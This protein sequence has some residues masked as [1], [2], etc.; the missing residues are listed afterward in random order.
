MSSG[1]E[2]TDVSNLPRISET[3]EPSPF[4]GGRDGDRSPDDGQT[5]IRRGPSRVGIVAVLIVSI[6]LA[7]LTSSWARRLRA[8][9]NDTATGTGGASSLANMNSFA[10]ALLLGG[11][12]GPLVMFLWTNSE[13]LKNEKNLEDFDTYVEWIR[14]LQPEFDTVHIFQVWNKAYNISVQMA[15]VG[16]KYIT[17]LDALDYAERVEASRPNNVSMIYQMGSIYYDKLGNSQ[18]KEYYKER[19]RTESKPHA[20]R[21]KLAK[22][23]PGWR[24]LELDPVL[25]DKGMILPELLKPKYPRPATIPASANGLWVNGAKLQFLEPYQ[26]FPYG[27]SAMAFGYNYH[28]QAQ[29]LQ[30][31]GGQLHANLSEPV[32]DSRPGLALKGWSEDEWERGRRVELKALGVAIPVERKDLETPTASLAVDVPISAENKVLLPEA[33]YD[34]DLA[35]RLSRDALADYKRH[36][37]EYVQNLQTY[38]SHIDSMEAQAPLLEADRDYLKAMLAPAGEERKKL[39][40]SAA[41]G[42]HDAVKHNIGIIFRYYI[43]EPVAQQVLP[44]GLTRA[45]VDK[46]DLTEDQML[47][48]YI[49]AMRMIGQAQFDPDAEDRGEYQ[50]YVDRA[51]LRLKAIGK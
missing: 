51:M 1:A 13:N 17:I 5:R 40:A 30:A 36:I 20:T 28:R 8:G 23:D 19:V 3:R 41:A 6:L 33:I 37:R 43:P 29:L 26:P 39:L 22:N 32:V 18:E 7:G 31:L 25:D 9:P 16:N 14:L 24:R 46:K 49:N 21:Q 27:V 10:L 34:Y 50:H 4:R 35:A 44:P 15:A 38:Q 45:D 48:A 42:Y 11:L 47:V 2:R 12:R